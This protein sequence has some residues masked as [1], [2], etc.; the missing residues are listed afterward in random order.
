VYLECSQC[1]DFYLCSKCSPFKKDVHP[2]SHIFIVR[3]ELEEILDEEIRTGDFHELAPG[4]SSETTRAES[5][6][7]AVSL[8][9]DEE[10][11]DDEEL[12]DEE[13]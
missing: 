4:D 5:R 6:V 8:V 1:H 11:D 3:G 9:L 13:S 12:I 10:S 2:E 7:P